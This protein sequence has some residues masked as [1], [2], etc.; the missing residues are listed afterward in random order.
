MA[1]ETTYKK[2]KPGTLVRINRTQEYG[3]VLHAKIKWDFAIGQGPFCYAVLVKGEKVSVRKGGL[4][5]IGES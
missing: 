4:T 5:V 3:I 2:I 1:R